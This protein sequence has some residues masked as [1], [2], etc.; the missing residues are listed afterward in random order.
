[1]AQETSEETYES[2]WV[3]LKVT[4]SLS[5]DYTIYNASY[6]ATKAKYCPFFDENTSLIVDLNQIDEIESKR[7]L[8]AKYATKSNGKQPYYHNQM[9]MGSINIIASNRY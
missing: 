8:I 5:F 9:Y 6:Y 4:S 2:C 1:M 3:P 7:K